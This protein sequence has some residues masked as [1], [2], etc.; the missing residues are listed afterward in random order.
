[1]G[2]VREAVTTGRLQACAKQLTWLP[3]S[4]QSNGSHHAAARM[5]LGNMQD[6]KAADDREAG[7]CQNNV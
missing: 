1:M 5:Q 6:T 4:A 2:K 7:S 3:I